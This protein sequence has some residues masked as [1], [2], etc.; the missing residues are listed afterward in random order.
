LRQVRL[1][2]P[3]A[4]TV[5]ASA[6]ALAGLIGI[7][8]AL[9]PEDAARF[10]LVRGVLPPGV[11]DAA[12]VLAL[13]FGIALV[14]LSRGLARRKRRAWQLSVALVLASA[15]AHM[16]KGLDF[17]EA[18]VTLL[19]LAALWRWR[20]SFDAPG[21]PEAVRPLVQVVLAAVAIAP[22]AALRGLDGWSY[23]D[24]IEDALVVLLG[25]LGF[26]A[27]Y[28]WLRPIAGRAR[29]TLAERGAAE[30]LVHERGDD[31]LCYFALRRDKSYFFSP[32]GDSFLAYRVVNGSA[33]VSG[34]PIGDRAEFA[35]L[36]RA[37]RRLARSRGW[38][39]GILGSNAELRPL[40]RS[41][42]LKPVYLGDEAVVH[43][44]RFSLEGRPIRKVRQSVH[45]LER[46]GYRVRLIRAGDADDALRREV[47]R[48]SAE[49]RGKWPERG[50]TM[51]MDAL[52]AYPESVL[53]LA[54]GPDGRLGGFIHLVPSP[55]SGGYSL[56]SMRRRRGTPNGLME[57]LIVETIGWARERDVPELSLNFS[58]FGAVLR[59]GA[60][61]PRA[62]RAFR[63]VL[64]RLDRLFQLERLHSF[65]RKF[66]PEWRPRY[67]CVERWLDFPLVGI[68]F[69][70]AESLLTPPGPW[71]RPADPLAA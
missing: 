49:W 38:R 6:A 56:A 42:G 14:W 21:D 34:D 35:E 70:H 66:F 58:V 48:V 13:A 63:L 37:F 28:L 23:S 52:F 3:T 51:A 32:S 62:Q 4:T 40:Y 26:R 60:D 19:L 29:Q 2:R 64:L 41:L 46:S 1:R 71:T 11:P 53:A 12:R 57:F 59:A 39:V 25:A 43:P 27:L 31:S 10:D 9:T 24:R 22:V 5:L 8:S 55:A 30:R 47:A 54:Q 67:V 36:V 20:R 15:A 65:N 7:V 18:S 17:E 45:R 16:A 68:G 61:A 44:A 69:L 50:F 33:L